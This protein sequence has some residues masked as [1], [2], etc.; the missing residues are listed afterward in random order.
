MSVVFKTLFWYESERAGATSQFLDLCRKLNICPLPAD[1]GK[2]AEQSRSNP[3]DAIRHT[4]KDFEVEFVDGRG[5]WVFS[6]SNDL[7]FGNPIGVLSFSQRSC[8]QMGQA[9]AG[10]GLDVLDL[11]LAV[12][13]E[14]SATTFVCGSD[15]PRSALVAFKR[16]N[17]NDVPLDL[18]YSCL[19]C[20]ANCETALLDDGANRVSRGGNSLLT[21]PYP[22]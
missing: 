5:I 12:A 19:D 22:S 17:L 13:D 18:V 16:G 21:R 14:L 8:I 15:T 1:A 6:I 4:N 7:S 11:V 20:P 9:L 3:L 2:A 10:T